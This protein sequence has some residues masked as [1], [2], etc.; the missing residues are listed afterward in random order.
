MAGNPVTAKSSASGTIVPVILI[1]LIIGVSLFLNIAMIDVRLYDLDQTLRSAAEN[2]D[3]NKSLG[4]L[5]KYAVVSRAINR[6]TESSEDYLM[7]AKINAVVSED[8]MSRNQTR[9]S[10]WNYVHPLIRMLLNGIRMLEGKDVLQRQRMTQDNKELQ[11]AYIYERNRKYRDAIDIYKKLMGTV[12]NQPRLLGYL[13]LHIGFC[14]SMIGNINEAKASYET[15]IEKYP[16]TETAR[17]AWKLLNFLNTLEDK[18]STVESGGMTDLQKGKNYYLLMD[19][20]KAIL[21]F[22][23]AKKETKDSSVIAQIDFL[24]ARSHE[25]LGE[26][27]IALDIYQEVLDKYPNSAQ[28]QDA[29]RRLY[30]MDNFYESTERI[31]AETIKRLS[32]FRDDQFFK[33]LKEISTIVTSSQEARDLVKKSKTAITEDENLLIADLEKVDLDGKNAAAQAAAEVKEQ[34]FEQAQIKSLGQPRSA[35]TTTLVRENLSRKPAYIAKIF[36]SNYGALRFIYQQALKTGEPLAGKM[37]VRFVIQPDG[38]LT[39]VTILDTGI[40][41]P[42][43]EQQVVEAISKIRFPAIPDS[44]GPIPVLFPIDFR[45]S[46]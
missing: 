31:K 13:H 12:Q 5:A 15:I 18:L 38:R 29:R 17:I 16:N 4:M 35:E 46:E 27:D 41:N 44:L 25:E 32:S 6:G 39:E 9:Q 36:S 45:Q 21:H 43:F 3:L 42:A 20:R 37:S 40:K 23:K 24:Q 7:E 14:Q 2:E 8:L 28:A 1:L 33:E 30:I 22:R 26:N 11:V 34:K 10:R 19:Y